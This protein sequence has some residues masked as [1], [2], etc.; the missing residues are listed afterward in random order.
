MTP[1]SICVIAK[2]E[3]VHMEAFLSSI[4]RHMKKYPYELVIIDTGST[5]KTIE[6]A[7]HYTNKVYQFEW[8]N[9]FSAARNYSLQCATFNWVLVL[10]C[11]EYL[12]DIKTDCF[13]QMITKYPK[14]V[15]LITRKNHCWSNGTDRIFTDSVNRFFNK[16]GIYFTFL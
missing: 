15:G 14:G 12:L 11:D 6:V 2:N 13:Q 9:D 16:I 4:K 7:H 10:D 1:I 5:D 8:V 3:E